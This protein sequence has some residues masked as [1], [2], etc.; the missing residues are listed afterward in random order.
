VISRCRSIQTLNEL[1]NCGT[2]RFCRRIILQPNAKVIDASGWPA[3][4]ALPKFDRS[5]GRHRRRGSRRQIARDLM[6]LCGGETV[7]FALLAATGENREKKAN[8]Q[9]R[10]ISRTA[11]F[12]SKE[13]QV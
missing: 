5:P 10:E 13:M 11:S 3:G 6:N 12:G 4:Y 7:L 2:I 9:Q 1:R 8:S